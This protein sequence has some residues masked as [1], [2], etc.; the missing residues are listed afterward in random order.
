M[1]PYWLYPDSIF[2][3]RGP[4]QD[5][6]RTGGIEIELSCSVHGG[7]DPKWRGIHPRTAS[8]LL[9]APPTSNTVY[10]VVR[11]TLSLA[12]NLL[13]TPTVLPHSA[14]SA[15]LSAHGFCPILWPS[16]I[17]C[18]HLFPLECRAE[19]GLDLDFGLDAKG[20]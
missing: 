14:P 3:V 4:G 15:P 18:P 7:K 6:S 1:R 13:A 19:R 8:S 17:F 10:L 2:L 5:S 12:H 11:L 20:G 16:L 9:S